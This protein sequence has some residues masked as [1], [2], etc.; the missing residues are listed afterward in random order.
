[1]RLVAPTTSATTDKVQQQGR[2]DSGQ[3][4]F[5]PSPTDGAGVTVP[6]GHTLRTSP[7]EPGTTQTTETPAS[8]TGHLRG[9][10]KAGLGTIS[11]STRQASA[12]HQVKN[13]QGTAC[14]LQWKPY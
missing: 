11:Y 3:I 9:L 4:S 2:W 10:G 7:P 12:L 5:L 6:C 13:T 1:M 8:Y 14:L